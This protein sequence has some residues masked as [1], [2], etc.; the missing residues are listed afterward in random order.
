MI[1]TLHADGS[2][3]LVQPDDFGRFHCEIDVPHASVEQVGQAFADIVEIES[4]DTAWVAFP[5]LLRLGQIRDTQ[6]ND[7]WTQSTVAMMQ[8]ARKHGWVRDQPLAI[9]SHIVWRT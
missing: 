9:K 5:A 6:A 3:G 2:V 7:N 4:R 8:M 1:L